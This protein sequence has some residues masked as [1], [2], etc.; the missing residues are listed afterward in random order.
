LHVNAVEVRLAQQTPV[1]SRRWRQAEVAFVGNLDENS[2][3]HP[4]LKFM[5]NFRVFTG[6]CFEALDSLQ[7]S[8]AF[9]SCFKLEVDCCLS[10][11]FLEC[12][13]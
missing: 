8:L 6:H 13:F 5:E 11:L 1:D 7:S 4:L 3:L 12:F 10:C 9:G 2:P